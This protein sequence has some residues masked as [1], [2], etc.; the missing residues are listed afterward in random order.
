MRATRPSASNCLFPS[1]RPPSAFV[2]SFLLPGRALLGSAPMPLSSSSLLPSHKPF[3]PAH[4][5]KPSV[6][7]RPLSGPTTDPFGPTKGHSRRVLVVALSLLRRLQHSLSLW[8]VVWCVLGL[9]LW[10]GV[11]LG[12]GREVSSRVRVKRPVFT[13]V[14]V[15]LPPDA[16]AHQWR[17]KFGIVE[18]EGEGMD[19]RHVLLDV[20]ERVS[21]QGRELSSPP[22]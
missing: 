1:S 7:P 14:V 8:K 6:S 4:N 18:V 20:I 13:E 11:S 21:A 16:R 12:G 9:L 5:R 17:D 22:D 10:A 3:R 2:L 15:Q 19:G